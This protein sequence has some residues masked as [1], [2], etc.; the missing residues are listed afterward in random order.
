MIQAA[1][2][3]YRLMGNLPVVAVDAHLIVHDSVS[4]ERSSITAA[5]PHGSLAPQ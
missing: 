3:S 2:V 1:F 4:F 5:V